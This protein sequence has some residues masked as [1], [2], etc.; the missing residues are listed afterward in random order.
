[1][2]DNH[3]ITVHYSS[4]CLDQAVR[5]I[6]RRR[7]FNLMDLVVSLALVAGCAYQ[8]LFQRVTVKS[9]VPVYG[10]ILALIWIR[11]GYGYRQLKRKVQRRFG[12]SGDSA[13]KMV[14]YDESIQMLSKNAEAKLLW[15]DVKAVWRLPQ[16]LILWWP[17]RRFAILPRSELDEKTWAFFLEK[18]KTGRER[19]PAGQA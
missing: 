8:V 6:W 2:T 7:P 17:D 3:E 4:Q 5:S 14:L 1:M 16:M 18:T 9:A 10:A 15:K 13:V 19:S 12:D 11:R